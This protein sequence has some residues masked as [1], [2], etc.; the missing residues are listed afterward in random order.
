MT[1]LRTTT[2]GAATVNPSVFWVKITPDSK[3]PVGARVL[4]INKAAGVAQIAPFKYDGW[5]THY[6]GLPVFKEQP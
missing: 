5:Y 4:L 3:P 2:D 6:A 1:G